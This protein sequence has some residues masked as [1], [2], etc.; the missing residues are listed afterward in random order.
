MAREVHPDLDLNAYLLLLHLTQTS[1]TRLTDTTDAFDADEA[2][3]SRPWNPAELMVRTGL[4]RR[5][6][7][8]LDPS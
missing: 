8:A 1:P 6:N 7:H 2:T 3:M 5:L 4:L